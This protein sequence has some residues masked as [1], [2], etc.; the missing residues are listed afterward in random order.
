MPLKLNR[1]LLIGREH[2]C[3]QRNVRYSLKLARQLLLFDCVFKMPRLFCY[4]WCVIALH[5]V[6]YSWIT[7]LT[8]LKAWL[9]QLDPQQNNTYHQAAKSV[10][11]CEHI[12]KLRHLSLITSIMYFKLSPQ[13]ALL[14]SLKPGVAVN[15]RKL[16][17]SSRKWALTVKTSEHFSGSIKTAKNWDCLVSVTDLKL[18]LQQ[19]WTE[20]LQRLNRQF[21]RCS[22]AMK[23]R[24]LFCACYNAFWWFH[25]SKS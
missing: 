11:G 16:N 19:E 5:E 17:W 9:P 18:W 20:G 12:L 15:C 22:W 4:P 3:A 13:K 1:N 10:G 21:K 8:C 25:K 23:L 6:I 7:F 14:W 2:F 24:Q